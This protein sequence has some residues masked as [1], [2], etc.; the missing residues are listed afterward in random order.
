MS[1]NLN[2]PV[3]CDQ[4]AACRPAGLE[5]KKV[6]INNELASRM[7]AKASR[8]FKCSVSGCGKTFRDQ[9]NLNTHMSSRVHKPK[10][11]YGCALC[12][13]ET[14]R[15]CNLAIHCRFAKH[16]RATEEAAT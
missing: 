11:V 10:M 2:I 12:G 7:S 13:Y 6:C 8:R 16:M 15:R 14:P 4:A 1:N 5:K 3:P 9:Y